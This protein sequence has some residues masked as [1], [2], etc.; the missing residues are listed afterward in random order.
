[1]PYELRRAAAVLSN[2]RDR[3]WI[4][5]LQAVLRVPG[6]ARSLSRIQR[7]IPKKEAILDDKT[8]LT[9]TTVSQREVGAKARLYY[10]SV[11]PCGHHNYPPWRLAYIPVF[12]EFLV[13]AIAGV[14]AV[15]AGPSV[16]GASGFSRSQQFAHMITLWFSKGID[17]PS[18][19][20][21]EF[22][23]P[24]Q[25]RL[26][27]QYLTRVETKNGLLGAINRRRRSPYPF[28]ELNHKRQFYDCCRLFGLPH[29]QLL[30]V[31]SS[32]GI[33]RLG[34]EEAF[35]RDLFCKP[36]KGC[37]AV[38]T[39][40][41]RYLSSEIWQGQEGIVLGLAD[42]HREVA[43]MCGNRPM[44]VQPRLRNHEEVADLA[45]DSLV[46]FRVVT[47]LA[48][49]GEPEVTLA[50][51]RVLAK[52]ETSWPQAT[53]EEYAAP[54]DL[55]MGTLGL[56]TGDS[57]KTSPLRHEVHP[58]TG[59]SVLGREIRHWPEVKSLALRAHR[60]FRTRSIIGWD[61]ALTPDGPVLLEGN[62]NLDVMFLQRVHNRPAGQ[63]RFGEF[64]SAQ[65]DALAMSAAT[66]RSRPVSTSS[67][68]SPNAQ[69]R[70]KRS[71]MNSG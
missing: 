13:I 39:L 22:W 61:I 28:H 20:E 29:P 12:R 67:G 37:G 53:D 64:L 47:C 60:C 65:I 54:I 8:A 15:R 43:S 30:A 48:D 66:P 59:A 5:L 7:F 70:Q 27:D 25:R 56:F 71:E 18:Y 35:N 46:T 4:N 6:R 63:T 14:L 69:I 36:Q 23:R 58:L 16:R 68:C 31:I 40:T 9:I 33:E 1:M 19:Y 34:S 10:V 51:L 11:G 41:F 2:A 50:M 26:V 62:N 21:Q 38:G 42:L 49:A 44:L 57:M 55:S 24:R 3:Y 32:A 17:P 52:L 45:V